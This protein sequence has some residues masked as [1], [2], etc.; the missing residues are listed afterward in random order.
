MIIFEFQKNDK[1]DIQ[2]HM[3]RTSDDVLN[4]VIAW[5]TTVKRIWGYPNVS[6]DF[7]VCSFLNPDGTLC[8]IQANHV[9]DWLR[10]ILSLIREK[11]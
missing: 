8:N 9:R 11:C 7:K 3:F 6:D 2:I 4:P 10:T 1:R 5:A